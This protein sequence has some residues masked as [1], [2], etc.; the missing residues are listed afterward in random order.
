MSREKEFI[1]KCFKE[2]H[3]K[4]P[5]NFIIG[6]GEENI[7]INIKDKDSKNKWTLVESNVSVE[8]MV[9]LEKKF[10]IELPNLYK[11]FISSYYYSFNELHGVLDNFLYEDDCDVFVNVMQQLPGKPLAQIENILHELKDIINYGYIPIGDFNNCGPICFDTVN[12]YK[13]VWLDHEE[14]YNCESREELEEVA[15]PIFVDFKQFM[16]CFFCGI[17]HECE[18]I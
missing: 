8:D 15:I 7:L 6:N 18:E 4:H 5:E 2:L 13:L 16:E 9:K 12:N 14:Y 1:Q 11:A 17:K 3:K 10:N